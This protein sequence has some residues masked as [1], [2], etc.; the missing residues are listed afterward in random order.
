MNRMEEYRNLMLELDTPVPELEHTSERAF[1]RMRRRK[2]ILRP[3]SGVAASFLLFVML[4][5]FWTP[6]AYACSKIPILK[7]LAEAV[8]FSPSLKK[9]VDNDYVQPL[10]L[11]QKDGDV[12]ASIE[13]LI[14]DQKQVNVFYRL[15]SEIYT[16][17]NAEPTVLQADGNRHASCSYGPNDWDVPN[18]D[19]QSITI[20]FVDQD[21]PDSLRLKLNIRDHEAW[22]E[23][24]P[25]AYTTVEDAMFEE[26]SHDEQGFVAHF[27]FLLEFDPQFTAAGK[28]YEINETV[29]LEGQKI[30]FTDIE[31]YPSHLRVNIEESPENTAWINRLDFYIETDFGMTFDPI[32]DGITATGTLDSPSMVSYRA[33]SSYFYDA[34]HLKI[35]V[36]GAEWLKKDMEK[37]HVNLKTGETDVLPEGVTFHNASQSD[38]GWLV[39]FQGVQRRRNHTYQLFSQTYYDAVGNEYHLDSW[40]SSFGGTSPNGK[41][42]YF[43]E[44]FPLKDYHEEDV[45]LCPRYSHE[46]IAEEPITITVH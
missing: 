30:T 5:N 2:Q 12:T 38:R 41:E 21:V 20:D 35:V 26:H 10:H 42:T 43:I 46:W 45:W 17:M 7:E 19:L 25:A 39:E 16:H 13:Y 18:G 37:V 28:Y 14:V 8:T 6:A 23:E 4:V 44:M 29:T 15:N 11:W 1:R 3:L 34:N 9:A 27:D 36:T 22:Q 32:S 33:D 24:A 40:S 31:I